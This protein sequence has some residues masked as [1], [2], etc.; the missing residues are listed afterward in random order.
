VLSKTKSLAEVS[1]INGEI[2]TEERR[3]RKLYQKL[4]QDYFELYKDIEPKDSALSE[5]MDEIQKS[6]SY[7][8]TL[9]ENIDAMKRINRCPHCGAEASFEMAYCSNCGEKLPEVAPTLTD[10][11]LICPVCHREVNPELAYCTFCRISLRQD[12][13]SSDDEGEALADVLKVCPNCGIL[14]S[15]SD[16]VCP[17]CGFILEE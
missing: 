14:L 3:I 4:G 2:S 16:E 7:L 8:K 1:K 17:D 9:T 10:D 13:A 11:K 6:L 15:A 12:S 5:C